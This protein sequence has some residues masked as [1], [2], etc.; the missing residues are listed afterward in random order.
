MGNMMTLIDDEL[1]EE[2]RA[3]AKAISEKL[4]EDG[5][6]NSQM[7]LADI[8]RSVLS[9]GQQFQKM[10]TEAIIEA[11]D[12]KEE[13]TK[14]LCP[15]CGSKMRHQGYRK[16]QI[17]TETGEVVLRRAYYRCEACGEGFFPPG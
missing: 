2:M 5:K 3:Q 12:Q 1:K 6:L 4:M 14:P 8:E 13:R 16:R 7:T 17:V 15:K 10:L 11:T 9:T